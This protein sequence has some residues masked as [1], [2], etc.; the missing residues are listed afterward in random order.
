MKRTSYEMSEASLNK[1]LKAM[2][3]VPYIIVGGVPPTS[4]QENANAA[5]TALGREMGFDPM[6][7]RPDGQGNRYFTAEAI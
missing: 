5:W 1:L 2:Q 3:P 4:Q 6:T 7:V